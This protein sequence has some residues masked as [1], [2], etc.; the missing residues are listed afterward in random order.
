LI[1][2]LAGPFLD[3]LLERQALRA[4]CGIELA[5]RRDLPGGR[6]RHRVLEPRG[7]VRHAPA[8]TWDDPASD[9]PNIALTRENWEALAPF[10]RSAVYVNDL[11]PDAADRL[12]EVY[13]SQKL[14]RLASLKP[15]WDPYNLFHLNANI[16]PAL[17]T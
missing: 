3:A 4:G 1:W 13:G 14:E 15:G 8:A 9:E 17:A 2:E 16:A 5:R 7:C 12:G 10:A 6:G 11:G